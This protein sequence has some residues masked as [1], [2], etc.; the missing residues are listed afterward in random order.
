MAIKIHKGHWR[1]LA[2]IRAFTS[3]KECE[4]PNAEDILT[5]GFNAFDMKDVVVVLLFEVYFLIKMV[6]EVSVNT[7]MMIVK[8]YGEARTVSILL[9][10]YR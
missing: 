3:V 2:Q 8:P 7:H 1:L 4:K 6:P 5:S 9:Q 10:M